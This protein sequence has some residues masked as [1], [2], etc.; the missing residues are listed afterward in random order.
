MRVDKTEYG[1]VYTVN[2]RPAR[3]PHFDGKVAVRSEARLLFP[4]A[5]EA[6]LRIDDSAW[7]VDG[8]EPRSQSE[9]IRL[10][11]RNLPRLS[12]IAAVHPRPT[13]A[14]RLTL[15]VREFAGELLLTTTLDIGIDEKVAEQVRRRQPHLG[16][17]EDVAQWLGECV[18]LPPDGPE[19][20]TRALM[21]GE[22]A[23]ES[24][25]RVAFRLL[26]SGVRVDVTGGPDD[27]LRVT[28]VVATGQAA[29]R[30]ERR[31][32][33]LLRGNLR[34][35]DATIAGQL[36]GRVRTELDQMVERAGSYLRVW[37]EYNALEN[38]SVLRR[39][40]ALGWLHYSRREPL[41][42]GR[43]RFALEDS[44][45]LAATL[46]EL[47]G[48]SD[49]AL[50][51]APSLPPELLESSPAATERGSAGRVW[52]GE[53][54]GRSL[55]KKTLDLRPLQQD[56]EETTAPAER[57]VLFV[58]LRGDQARLARREQAWERIAAAECPMPQLGLLIEG[59]PVPIRRPTAVD[60]RSAVVKALLGGAPN[61]SQL[62]A[63]RVA[64]NTPD[65]ALIQGPPGT[66]KTRTIAALQARL[67]EL[68]E[69]VR[70]ISGQTLL[71]SFQHDA[72]EN[73]ASATQ[74]FGLPAVKVGRR[75]GETEDNA[76]FERWRRERADAVR[77]DLAKLPALPASAA[78]R[79]VRDRAVAYIRSARSLDEAQ[80]VLREVADLA[81]DFLPPALRDHLLALRQRLGA[82][83]AAVPVP[84]A[85]TQARERALQAVHSLRSDPV[86]FADDGSRNAYRTMQRLP[87]VVHLA[88]TERAL[89][90]RAADWKSAQTP[91]FLD[92]LK[93]LQG[94]LLDRLKTTE[95]T[96]SS[97][98]VL[99]DVA[100]LLGQIT[101]SL[102]Q[103]VR[104]SA[105][106]E[107][108]ALHEYLHDLES[109]ALGV[110]IAVERYTA[111]L[112]A[113]CQ[114]AVAKAMQRAKGG[115]RDIAFDNVVVD[116]AARANP[117]DL[118]IPMATAR[119]R[120][121]L[122]GD[123]RQLP[124]I[125]EPDIEAQLE[126]SVAQETQEALKRS[127]F[128]RLFLS[129]GERQKQDN[130]PR[131]VTLNIQYRMHPTLGDFVSDTFYKPYG[132]GFT[133]G[134]L[135]ED[136]QHG[137]P[138]YG[139]AVAVWK[140][141]ALSQS[142][143]QGGQSKRRPVEA[144]WIARE[145]RRILDAHPHLSVGVI[146]FYTAQVEELQERM[147]S[148]KL[149]ER[150]HDGGLSIAE[151]Y[152]EL[153]GSSR[154]GERLRVG[155]VDAFQGK[156]FDVVFLS[157]TRSNDVVPDDERKVR[158]KWGHLTLANRLCVAMSRQRSL[159]FVV[160]D[161]GMLEPAVAPQNIRG[162]CA[163]YE[164]C[165]G[166]HGKRI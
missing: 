18:L 51:A 53:I 139:A 133:S 90:D 5:G 63:L 119:R 91:P 14:S 69:Q 87:A 88:D 3:G 33:S 121:I 83:F 144:Q 78:Y 122:V 98:K 124:H 150:H 4:T 106:G 151:S 108:A 31:P 23:A 62:A 113:T 59:A 95:R 159:L 160:G 71:S 92:E 126:Q 42:D 40:R 162:L 143:E 55:Q 115:D 149:V 64:L 46:G 131:V 16:R 17:V 11:E 86:P 94:V 102:R 137:I 140:N 25:R 1:I 19:Q 38:E 138:E 66:G 48:D 67:A 163:F 93:A 110:R 27:R 70:G 74:V 36:R 26:G 9:L 89:L 13:A 15:Q 43:W 50:E 127:L 134:V 2:L 35:C 77:A 116:E 39:A 130:N 101:E 153:S 41:P 65:I 6:L 125:L 128:Q 73:A 60:P 117:L 82:S 97:P 96:D 135:A 24:G 107:G 158:R 146:S 20:P 10:A 109:D 111:V 61:A 141:L 49:L 99:A 147:V 148:E 155:T 136:R 164:L 12:W 103:Q 145:C 22:P 56:E 118:F 120:I 29:S 156:E 52:V 58:S 37:K 114:Q 105:A 132:E 161:S 157:M 7:A 123:H 100:A 104:A 32:I 152:R 8:S 28:R 68:T 75:W 166:P 34:F 45:R 80:Q 85:S 21:T 165:G 81:G 44:D 84:D 154:S 129:L 142:P 72:V 57:G 30:S 79:A 76:G 54:A 47:A 112:A